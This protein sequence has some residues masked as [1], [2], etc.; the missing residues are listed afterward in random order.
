MNRRGV[1]QLGLAGGV[2]LALGG[3][4]LHLR[5][6][7]R[8]HRPRGPLHVLDAGEFAV[9]AAAAA[10]MVLVP[11]ADPV[12]IA[13]GVDEALTL[14]PPESAADFKKLLG[15][16]ESALA[17]LILDGRWESFTRL[18]AAG[19]DA[20]LYHFRDSRLVLRRSGYQALRKLCLGAYYAGESSWS[21][22]G[23]P[24]PPDIRL[25]PDYKVE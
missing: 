16:I 7:V 13:H 11:G 5:P 21:F 15:L 10:R 14:G 18:D 1:L 6:V 20:V 4:G 8:N 9:L 3:A 22:V 19:Q 17:G 25:P 2:L 12:T 23:Y 24:G